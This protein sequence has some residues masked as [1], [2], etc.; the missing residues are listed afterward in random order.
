MK[1]VE[2][3]DGYIVNFESIF[4]LQKVTKNQEESNLWQ[5]QYDKLKD[6]YMQ[7]LPP[8]EIGKETVEIDETEEGIQRYAQAVHNEIIDQIGLP[9]EVATDYIVITS[10]G[11]KIFITGEKYDLIVN[12]I[13]TNNLLKEKLDKALKQ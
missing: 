10:T 12:Y 5:M 11:G 7:N 3:I 4:S 9:P 13:N 8:I 1:F 6:V 2:L